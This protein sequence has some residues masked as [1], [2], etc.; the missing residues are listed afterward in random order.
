[1]LCCIV[2]Y[3]DANGNSVIR[4]DE[5]LVLVEKLKLMA[6]S[7]SCENEIGRI[8]DDLKSAVHLYH[9][10]VP[11]EI[12]GGEF[13]RRWATARILYHA[14]AADPKTVSDLPCLSLDD[15]TKE[16]QPLPSP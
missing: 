13:L 1:M 3:S 4:K 11:P 16:S 9:D 5:S 6:R 8:A 12:C 2:L 14:L 7:H 10:F 15:S